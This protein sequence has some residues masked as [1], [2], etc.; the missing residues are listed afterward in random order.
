MR[1]CAR[2]LAF[3]VITEKTPDRTG[4]D[5]GHG[6]FEKFRDVVAIMLMARRATLR[7]P[8]FEIMSVEAI[9]PLPKRRMA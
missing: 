8:P 5:H 1:H 9:T 7:P 3:L 2:H 6:R 4:G